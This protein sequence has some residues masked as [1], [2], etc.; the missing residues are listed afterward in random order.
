MAS[1]DDL[2]KNERRLEQAEMDITKAETVELE[3]REMDIASLENTPGWKAV[4]KELQEEVDS[5]ERDIFDIDNGLS[6]EQIEDLRKRRYYVV[7]LINLPAEKRD[8]F[9]SRNVIHTGGNTSDEE[10]I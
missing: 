3:G 2:E 9:L 4:V 1:M 5:L 10:I 7:R 8:L 6:N